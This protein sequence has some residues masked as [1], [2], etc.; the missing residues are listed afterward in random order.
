MDSEYKE[1]IMKN[2]INVSINNKN[3]QLL[4]DEN[5]KLKSKLIEKDNHIDKL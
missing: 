3:Y 5:E 4:S 2:T 1:N